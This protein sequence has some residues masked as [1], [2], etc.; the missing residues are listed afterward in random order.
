MLMYQPQ[1]DLFT[2]WYLIIFLMLS[3]LMPSLIV[4]VSSRFTFVHSIYWF[5]NLKTFAYDEILSLDSFSL[6]P[7]LLLL[8]SLNYMNFLELEWWLNLKIHIQ[9]ECPSKS[10]FRF[11]I[12]NFIQMLVKDFKYNMSQE[13]LR[14]FYPALFIE[15]PILSEK[16]L[17]EPILM[18]LFLSNH[19]HQHMIWITL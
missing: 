9:T 17:L 15:F 4:L 14:S 6:P 12:G 18:Y 1:H 2:Y 13:K 5:L 10:S 16:I 8:I 7:L 19:L 11:L 3:A